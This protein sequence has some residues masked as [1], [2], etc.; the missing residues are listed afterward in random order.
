M[1]NSTFFLLLDRRKIFTVLRDFDC[2]HEF[3]FF[4]VVTS[5]LLLFTRKFSLQF[6][7]LRMRNFTWNRFPIKHL[8]IDSLLTPIV[9]ST[10]QNAS[11]INVARWHYSPVNILL[12]S[13]GFTLLNDQRKSMT[14]IELATQPYALLLHS[15]NIY[16]KST[17]ESYKIRWTWT[18]DVTL[19]RVSGRVILS[20]SKCVWPIWGLQR[21]FFMIFRVT[22][23][24][25]VT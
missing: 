9:E 12:R 20:L 6:S 1:S 19:A 2:C 15:I 16:E 17:S 11:Q 23:F 22:I 8:L 13:L 21:N 5:T 14:A 18:R 10:N 24:S 7:G 25:F 3:V 4:S